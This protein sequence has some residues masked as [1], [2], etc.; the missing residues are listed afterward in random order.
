ME[1]VLASHPP[2]ASTGSAK[3]SLGAA[4]APDA[5]ALAATAAKEDGDG[6]VLHSADPLMD[7]TIE[8][9]T[10][11]GVRSSSFPDSCSHFPLLMQP[12]GVGCY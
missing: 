7:S 3:A 12:P 10:H 8:S 5:A 1:Q 2:P 9:Q 6:Y 11:K 4:W